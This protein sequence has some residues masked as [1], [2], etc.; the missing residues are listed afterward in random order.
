MRRLAALAAFG[1]LLALFQAWYVYLPLEDAATI[2]ICRINAKLDCYRS[3]GRF[4]IDMA[5][6]GV[7][8]F[9]TLAALFLFQLA[10]CLYCSASQEPL[11]AAWLAIARLTAFPQAGLALYVLLHDLLVAEATSPSAILVGAVAGAGCTMAILHGLR[12]ASIA[13]GVRGAALLAVATLAGAYAYHRGEVTRQEVGAIELERQSRPPGVR[14]PRF[15]QAMPRE[16]V[17]HLGN[18]L[19]ESEI[20]LFVDPAQPESR[21]L[22]EEAAA[23]ALEGYPD[24]LLHFYAPGDA[25][26]A[27]LEAESAGRVREYLKAPAAGDGGTHAMLGRIERARRKLGVVA[28][29]TA[30]WHGGGETGAFRLADVIRRA[31][32]R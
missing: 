17:A 26:A 13:H 4:G 28:Y 3:L 24:L 20:L 1:S 2:D 25:M 19:A 10:C 6:F 18:P 15:A 22:M 31:S 7:P 5:P 11:R 32:K 12:W 23:L 27:L 21:A 8:V 16:G 14:W 29:P 9:A 30:L